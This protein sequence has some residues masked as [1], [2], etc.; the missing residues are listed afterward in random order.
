[1][2]SFAC[3]HCGHLVFFENTVCLN[4]STPLGFVPER[5]DMAALEGEDAQ[6]L[7]RCANLALAQCNWMVERAGD[8]CASCVLTRTRPD[9]EDTAGLTAFATA[10]VAK[11]R[12]IM[13]LLDIGLPGVA[14]GHL[15][16]DLLSS[17]Q[18]PV[19]TGHAGGVITI[20]LAESDDARREQRRTEFGEPY[21][22]MLGH[23][24][25]ELG[26]YFQPLIVLGDD[27]WAA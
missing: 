9:D 11:R 20:D 13:Q 26:H 17:E 21:R 22:T 12:V 10:E 3:G 4:C 6:R 2:L 5:M 7:H 8:L 14:P 27:G 15:A 25:H 18:E 16:F 23:L 24:R 1:M 19:A